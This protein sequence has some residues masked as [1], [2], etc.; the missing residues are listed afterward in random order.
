MKKNKIPKSRPLAD[1]KALNYRRFRS[2]VK[3]ALCASAHLWCNRN[4]VPKGTNAC[5]HRKSSA[6][7]AEAG[8]AVHDLLQSNNIATHVANINRERVLTPKPTAMKV[9]PWRE[10]EGYLSKTQHDISSASRDR[11]VTKCQHL[12]KMLINSDVAKLLSVRKVTTANRRKQTG[13]VGKNVKIALTDKEKLDLAFSLKLGAKSSPIRRVDAVHSRCLQTLCLYALEPQYEATFVDQSSYGFRPGRSAHDAIEHLHHALCHG[14][15]RLVFD[16]NLKGC[17]DNI[18]HDYLLNKLNTFPEIKK[19]IRFFL[20]AGVMKGFNSQN[21]WDADRM[22]DNKTVRRQGGVISPLLVNIAL[23]RLGEHIKSIGEKVWEEGYRGSHHRVDRRQWPIPTRRE[24]RKKCV[25]VRYADNF[26]VMHSHKLVMDRIIAGVKIWLAEAGLE[27]NEEKSR[28]FDTRERF[29]FLGFTVKHVKTVAKTHSTKTKGNYKTLITPSKKSLNK[30]MDEL[31]FLVH[32]LSQRTKPLLEFI[33]KARPKLAGWCN[34][35]S[36]SECS[37]SFSQ[38][39]YRLYKSV[40]GRVMRL[41]SRKRSKGRWEKIHPKR[42]VY[43]FQRKPHTDNWV[44]ASVNQ[45]GKIISFLPKA[46]WF[47]STKH[48]MVDKKKQPYDGDVAY[49][50]KRLTCYR[51]YTRSVQTLLRIQK[52]ICTFCKEPIRIGDKIEVDHKKP[53]AS[54]KGK[55]KKARA[56][57]YKNLQA[58]HLE[59]HIKKTRADLA[60]MA[61]KAKNPKKARRKTPSVSSSK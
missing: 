59:C 14:H 43:F 44:V 1:K 34:Y 27:L 26:V 45:E 11:N 51:P 54:S 48:V 15:S 60:K 36:K 23:D 9:V 20:K 21:R 33:R 8:T 18:S 47:A 7:K 28:V 25:F 3:P 37:K 12:Q 56:S 57:A 6:I 17:L 61:K 49:W 52:G 30:L 35:F 38:I 41:Y 58:L 50:S 13:N 2:P 31:K 32:K 46:A 40:K 19:Q 10:L 16:A 29:N 24:A 42:K 55:R 4:I 53:K 22:P 39:D 5:K